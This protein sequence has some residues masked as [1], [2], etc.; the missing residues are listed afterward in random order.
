LVMDGYFGLSKMLIPTHEA[1]A[2]YQLGV[3]KF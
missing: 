1:I 3:L 2:N